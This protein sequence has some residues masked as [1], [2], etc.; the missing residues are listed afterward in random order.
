MLCH[1]FLFLFLLLF[2]AYVLDIYIYIYIYIFTACVHLLVTASVVHSSPILVTLMKEALSSPETSV[3]TE[4]QCVTSHMTL[5]FMR[6][7]HHF[8]NRI[9]CRR[10]TVIYAH[11]ESLT[12]CIWAHVESLTGCI[13]FRPGAVNLATAGHSNSV[14]LQECFDVCYVLLLK[15]LHIVDFLQEIWFYINIV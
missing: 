4:R 15:L 9:I 8:R 11:V 7:R 5:F 14:R 2:I 13:S 10:R 12:G 1:L 6:E 3:L